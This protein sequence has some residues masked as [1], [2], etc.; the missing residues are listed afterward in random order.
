MNFMKLSPSLVLL[1]GWG[2]DGGGAGDLGARPGAGVE[3]R[4]AGD[5]AV[6]GAGDFAPLTGPGDL[7]PR[8][9]WRL[10]VSV[11]EPSS[12]PSSLLRS[13]FSLWFR[14][15]SAKERRDCESRSERDISITS[16]NLLLSGVSGG[17]ADAGLPLIGLAAL[18]P[19]EGDLVSLATVLTHT[20]ARDSSK[21]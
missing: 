15:G 9:V 5:L 6:R 11:I 16:S 14:D 4:G 18:L 1:G 10:Q 20:L 21:P 12:A 13:C 2:E 7:P 3:V 19:G 17:G 8:P